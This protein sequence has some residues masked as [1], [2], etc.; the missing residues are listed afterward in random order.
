MN[1][2]VISCLMERILALCGSSIERQDIVRNL[3]DHQFKDTQNQYMAQLL[4]YFAGFIIPFIISIFT[5]SKPIL[6]LCLIC[7]LVVTAISCVEE[8]LKIGQSRYKYFASVSNLLNLLMVVLIFCFFI[9]KGSYA[10]S[11]SDLSVF[12]VYSTSVTSYSSSSTSTSSS[13]SSS[14]STSNSYSYNSSNIF[15][16]DYVPNHRSQSSPNEEDQELIS[17]NLKYV[18][19]LLSSYFP[20]VQAPSDRLLLSSTDEDENDSTS[21]TIKVFAII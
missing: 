6:V 21:S 8:V 5:T 16:D 13:T 20:D 10:M 4:A 15:N 9:V 12:N 14:S 2:Y 18:D 3:I 19:Y 11:V 7:C 1:D 17:G